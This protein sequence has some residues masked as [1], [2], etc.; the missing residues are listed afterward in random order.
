M[1]KAPASKVKTETTAPPVDKAVDKQTT[2]YRVARREIPFAQIANGMFRD[3]TVSIEARGTLGLIMT[4]PP[5]WEVRCQWL[6]EAI[7]T[8]RD[9]V[10]GIIKELIKAGYCKREQVR[11]PDGSMGPCVYTFTDSPYGVASL[12]QTEKPSAA[13]E[14][15]TP[16][17]VDQ[18]AI[19]I[20]SRKEYEVSESVREAASKRQV[21]PDEQKILEGFAG[22][23]IGQALIRPEDGSLCVV[24]ELRDKW[25]DLFGG[26]EDALTLALTEIRPFVP[27][28][29]R[30]AE[31]LQMT[32][33]AQL[34]KMTRW[35]RESLQKQRPSG[36]MP[37]GG[38]RNAKQQAADNCAALIERRRGELAGKGAQAKPDK[39]DGNG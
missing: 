22:L 16:A 7:G 20:D 38:Y 9:K 26:D 24:A 11:N 12:P 21:A 28:P 37:A 1:S 39:G 19:R 4:Y 31:H 30:N 5:D 23:P 35:R 10:R 33:N 34:A 18:A 8:G 25:L 14:T 15:E 27:A 13:P 29:P 3:K 2:I 36:S 6:T 32:V 17:P